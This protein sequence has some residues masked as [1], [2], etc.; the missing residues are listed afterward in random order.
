[1]GKLAPT[2]KDAARLVYDWRF[3]GRPKQHEPLGDWLIWLILAG[4]GFGKTRTG[5]EWVRQ[6]VAAGARY[7]YLV[8]P[9]E[10]AVEITML[11][12]ESGLLTIS[13][14]WDKPKFV[15]SQRRLY[16]KNGA[17]G[18]LFSAERPDNL[19]GPA[20]D[21]VWADE[22]AAWKYPET[23][24][25]VRFGLRSQQSGLVPRACITT[26]PRPTKLIRQ[27]VSDTQV[28]VTRGS[29]YEN[30][31]NL[32]GTFF[33]SVT[34]QYEGTRLGRQ[35]LL[36]EIL[37]DAPG[38][39]WQRD[40]IDA[41]RVKEAPPLRKIVIAV[42]PAVSA[43]RPTA[44]AD[45]DPVAHAE[46]VRASNET[47]IL[48]GGVSGKGDGYVLA[49][50]SGIYTPNEWAE[51]VVRLFDHYQ[52]DHIVCEVNQGGDL[53]A[54]NLRTIRRTLPIHTVRATRG[55]FTRAEPVAALYEQKRVH[56]V[57]ALAQLEDQLCTW[58]ADA[59]MPSPDRLDALV[60]LLTD[61]MV[62]HSPTV[63]TRRGTFDRGASIDHAS[64]GF[65]AIERV[66]AGFE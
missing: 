38:A 8:G 61:L 53:V 51:N 57:G 6:R 15:P 46:R 32:A 36:A 14:P 59:G 40:A 26:T 23:W 43:N 1:M 9:T 42:D 20:A 21:T 47:G 45:R 50:A 33:E 31:S 60:W 35:E 24:D 58:E 25:Q 66:S 18:I 4:R 16:W 3:N 13:P 5:A 48:V 56:H 7:V 41:L 12:G 54:N 29:T 55:K 63:A 28:H 49:D 39:L 11:Q 27:L 10:A 37:D 19:R 62:A 2:S 52:A 65:E 22:L 44:K 30:A 34:K 17:V 64:A